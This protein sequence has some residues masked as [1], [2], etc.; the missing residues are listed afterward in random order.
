[1]RG[2]NWFKADSVDNSSDSIVVSFSNHWEEKL[3]SGIVKLVFRRRF[4]KSF[5]AKKVYLYVGSPRS[6]FIGVADIESVEAFSFQKA[7]EE[8]E[9]AAISEGD[10][11]KYFKGYE[12]IGGYRLSKIRLFETPLALRYVS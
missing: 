11:E 8:R 7:L 9:N 10:L 1:M 4:P 6:S 2:S 5:H 12:E 3:E